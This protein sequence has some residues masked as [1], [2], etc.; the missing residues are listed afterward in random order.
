MV[1]FLVVFL[2]GSGGLGWNFFRLWKN[3]RSGNQSQG[4]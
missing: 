1:K 3:V 4:G 2:Q